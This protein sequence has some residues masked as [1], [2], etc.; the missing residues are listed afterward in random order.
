MRSADSFFTS[1]GTRV[2]SLI[3][4]Y[5]TTGFGGFAGSAAAP[6]GSSAGFSRL[7]SC[8]LPSGRPLSSRYASVTT[9]VSVFTSVAAWYSVGR[10]LFA[11][12]MKL[13]I[14]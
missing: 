1:A 9:G 6:A 13:A 14:V 5:S 2:F 4:K 8:M 12:S 3:R 10:R 7:S 11:L